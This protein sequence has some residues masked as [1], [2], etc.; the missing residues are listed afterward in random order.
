MLRPLKFTVCSH[1]ST[2]TTTEHTWKKSRLLGRLHANPKFGQ[3]LRPPF[4]LMLSTEEEKT[5]AHFARF[6]SN[7]E[8]HINQLLVV[9]RARIEVSGSSRV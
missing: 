1:G 8:L 9:T 3:L 4:R 5:V 2:G 7:E 6:L